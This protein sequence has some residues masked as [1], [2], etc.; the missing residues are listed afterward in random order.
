MITASQFLESKFGKDKRPQ[1]GAGGFLL[2][3]AIFPPDR[4]RSDLRWRGDGISLANKNIKGLYL[5]EPLRGVGRKDVGETGA[6]TNRK[7]GG[8]TCRFVSFVKSELAPSRQQC[9]LPRDGLRGCGVDVVCARLE[10]GFHHGEVLGGAGSIEYNPAQ[11]AP[12]EVG[13]SRGIKGIQ[14]GRGDLEGAGKAPFDP[15][16][17]L[18]ILAGEGE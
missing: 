10:T 17:F 2:P 7:K 5:I 15:C 8:E 9:V 12:N 13:H 16:S 4:G 18:P 1:S 3:A 6:E 14:R 11:G